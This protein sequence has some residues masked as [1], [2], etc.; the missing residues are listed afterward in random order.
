[1]SF[2]KLW[3]SGKGQARIG[4]GWPSRRKAFKLEP[5]PRVFTKVGC[6]PPTN[7]NHHPI[8]S[9]NDFLNKPLRGQV[10]QVE[11]REYSGRNH[12]TWT[13]CIVKFSFFGK[14]PSGL[15]I[16]I[17]W[18]HSNCL[19][20]SKG[21]PSRGFLFLNIFSEKFQFWNAYL[22]GTRWYVWIV[23]RDFCQKN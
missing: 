15:F 7:H 1:M 4:K 16:H 19:K 9:L 5:L 21:A 13:A 2:T 17:T 22:N 23:L 8:A 6:K 18:Y 12:S 10:R 3:S 20:S 14:N 11:V